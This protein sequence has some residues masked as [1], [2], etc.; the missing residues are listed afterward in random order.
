MQNSVRLLNASSPSGSSLFFGTLAGLP[1][2]VWQ[3]EVG[4]LRH[5][6]RR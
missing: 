1:L 6:A 3:N 4:L 2:G 5:A